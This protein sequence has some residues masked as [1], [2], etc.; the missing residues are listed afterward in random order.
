MDVDGKFGDDRK[1]RALKFFSI[2]S[3][4]KSRLRTS[5]RKR[6]VKDVG[7]AHV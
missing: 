7:W 4:Q 5:D 3:I 6:L 1:H 2:L